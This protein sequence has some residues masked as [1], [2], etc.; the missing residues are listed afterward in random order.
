[1][2]QTKAK[3]RT[4]TK[5][6]EGETTFHVEFPDLQSQSSSTVHSQEYDQS[7]E[8]GYC[9]EAYQSTCIIIEREQ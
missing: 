3:K 1:M 2:L 8:G 4:I 6:N 7:I 5:Q 9:D